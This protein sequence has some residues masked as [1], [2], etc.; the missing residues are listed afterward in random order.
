[1]GLCLG[2]GATGGARPLGR[3]T[4][5]IIEKSCTVCVEVLVGE[6]LD[7]TVGA[8]GVAW[9][10]LVGGL[11]RLQCLLLRVLLL[12]LLLLL[13]YILRLHLLGWVIV[14]HKI[15]RGVS[16]IGGVDVFLGPLSLID[17][18]G[19]GRGGSGIGAVVGIVITVIAVIHVV[20]IV[21]V[22]IHLD[23][24]SQGTFQGRW[25]EGGKLGG[26][27]LTRAGSLKK[28]WLR[29]QS[30]PRLVDLFTCYMFPLDLKQLY[31]FP[32]SVTLFFLSNES[33]KVGG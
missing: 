16:W 4:S 24:N 8:V 20:S 3:G 23:S 12:L 9:A 32:M 19:E 5:P 28:R 13:L 11:G 18:L 14:G 17:G 30:S 21:I 1:M 25:G 10:G 6:L 31:V 2:G 7:Q 22:G 29:R 33:L 26:R 27:E 15:T